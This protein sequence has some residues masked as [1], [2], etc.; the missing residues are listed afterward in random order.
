MENDCDRVR[1]THLC[2]LISN[3][4]PSG[5]K[6]NDDWILSTASNAHYSNHRDWFTIYTPFQSYIGGI[7]GGRI[8]IEG[9]GDVELRVRN[10]HRN[11]RPSYSI[12]TLKDVL[13]CPI[14]VCN[15][16][17]LGCLTQDAYGFFIGPG[18]GKITRDHVPIGII[19]S[20]NV[21][22]LRL[23]GQSPNQTSRHPNGNYVLSIIWPEEEFTRWQ[24]VKAA[25]NTPP[26]WWLQVPRYTDEEKK[27]LKDHWGG[28]F[29]FLRGYGLKI[30]NEEDRA[31]GREMVRAM[32][33]FADDDDLPEGR[34]QPII[35]DEDVH[36]ADYHFSEDELSWIEKYYGNSASFLASYGLKFHNDEDCREGK[37]MLH[38]MMSDDD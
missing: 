1:I 17:S 27:W 19:D 25:A 2:S 33:E 21:L 32:M 6:Y 23:N 28:E 14:A 12:I 22:K 13:Y 24:Q 35:P 15:Q 7:M 10:P 9:I 31:E 11:A 20:P 5:D 3:M 4:P 30:H 26:N 36:L 29:H 8:K 34:E 18:A 16:V 38:A 37:Q